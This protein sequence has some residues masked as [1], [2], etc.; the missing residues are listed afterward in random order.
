MAKIEI[1]NLTKNFGTTTALDNINLV[2]EENKIYGLLGRNGAGKTT[3]LSL[4]SNRIFPNT[5]EIVFD[6]KPVLEND[7]V[8]KEIYCTTEK[9]LLPENMKVKELFYWTGE[10]YKNFDIKRAEELAKLFK[11]NTSKKIKGLST[12]YSTIL[13]NI[14]GLSVNTQVLFLDE[15][16]L[17]LDANH[18]DLFYKE[19]IKSYTENPRTIVISTHLIEEVG[20]IIENVIVLKEGKVLLVDEVE[21]VLQRGYTISGPSE[22]VD[23]FTVNKNIIGSDVLGGLKSVYVYDEKI[24]KA[25]ISNNLEV[26]KL[27]LQKLFIHLTNGGRE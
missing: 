4:A 19:L 10:F 25:D 24:I 12:G 5:G 8:L 1:K 27:S 2:L 15:P 26:S 3:M 11:L 13:K 23:K 17:G 16:V 6:G 20:D 7:E 18:R 14:I 9:S 22:A 21:N